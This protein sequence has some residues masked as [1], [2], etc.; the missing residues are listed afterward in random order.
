M[1][2]RGKAGQGRGIERRAFLVTSGAG[3]IGSHTV[4][5]L[6]DAGG[7]VIVLDDLSTGDRA[8]VP[9]GMPFIQGDPG[10][11]AWTPR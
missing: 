11:P 9:D 1:G 10:L 8:L 2:N 5:A 3:D 7:P 4:L 6:A